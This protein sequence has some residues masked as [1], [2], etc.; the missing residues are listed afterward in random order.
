MKDFEK[1]AQEEKIRI[2]RIRER[3]KSLTEQIQQ[4]KDGISAQILD[5]KPEFS[6]SGT[7]S[8]ISPS[9]FSEIQNMLLETITKGYEAIIQEKEKV[10]QRLQ[11][12]IDHVVE[13][14]Q[15]LKQTQEQQIARVSILSEQQDKSVLELI[16]K[17]TEVESE[18]RILKS[19]ISELQQQ[20]EKLEA[21]AKYDKI[22]Y[23]LSHMKLLTDTMKECLRYFRTPIGMINEAFELVKDDIDGHPAHKKFSLIQQEILR[24]R[25][26]ITAVVDRLKFPEDVTLQKV[27]LRNIIS[28][29]LSKFQT[30]FITKNIEVSQQIN[31]DKV[32]VTANF[33]LLVDCLSE[34]VMNSIESFFQ[35]IGN[36]IFVKI[37]EEDNYPKLIIE[38][39]GCGIPEH[40]LPKV[41]NLFFTTK[42][43]QG[44]YGIGLFKVRWCLKMFDANVTI[45]S[46]FNKGTTV[47]VKFTQ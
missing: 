11:K 39:N 14:Y 35:P 33:Q 44:H 45:H 41:F 7:A 43:E 29:V 46:V 20:R 2:E 6:P 17:I 40:L 19:K 36:R 24:I 18:N 38:D 12:E 34:V 8:T 15:Q 26:I 3:I 5:I 30:D 21:S 37:E 27:D 22:G 1:L 9:L 42:F 25:D 28:V 16:K 47:T 31:T 13:K 23:V 32:Y 10:I 4:K